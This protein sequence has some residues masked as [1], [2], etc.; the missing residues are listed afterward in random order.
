[1]LSLGIDEK[2]EESRGLVD[3]DGARHLPER[4]LRHFESHAARTGLALVETDSGDL[5]VGEDDVRDDAPR[6]AA[7]RT[8]GE[9]VEED[10]VVVP[11]GVRELRTA[12]DVAHGVDALCTGPVT[13]VDLDEA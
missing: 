8:T 4:H 5:R 12:C 1:S 11:R 7:R 10:A 2:L 9:H 13:I 3:L 6:P